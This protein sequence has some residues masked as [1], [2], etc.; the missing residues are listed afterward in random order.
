VTYKRNCSNDDM[1]ESM[2]FI[3]CFYVVIRILVCVSCVLLFFF[4]CKTK[5]MNGLPRTIF[6]YFEFF[7]TCCKK[8]KN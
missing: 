5:M 4:E 6:F 8:Q 1:F 2:I 3:I 7:H